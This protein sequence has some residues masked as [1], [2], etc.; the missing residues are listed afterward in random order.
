M[1][2]VHFGAGNIGR[3]FI[4]LLLHKAGHHV[5]FVDVD[6]DLIN[7]INSTSSYRVIETGDSAQTHTVTDFSGLNSS[8]D[9]EKVVSAI[10]AADI[11]TTAVGP[12]VLPFIAPLIAQALNVRTTDSPLAIMACENAL[13]ATDVLRDAVANLTDAAI[14]TRAVFANTAVDRIVPVQDQGRGLDVVVETF[15]EWIVDG[16]PFVGNPPVV[17]GAHFVD[18]LAPFIERKLFTVNTGHASIAYLG[19]LRGA[20]TIAE[21]LAL[22]EVE[23]TVRKVLDETAEVLVARH[24]FDHDALRE[25]A[26][27]TLGRFRNPDLVDGVDRVGRQPMR[28]LSRHERLIEPSASLAERGI[29]ATGLLEV[30][31]AAF[32]FDASDDAES[33]ELQFLVAQ[34]GVDDLCERVCGITPEHPLF[35]NLVSALRRTL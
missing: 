2:A 18:D 29:T 4:G 21:A 7:K 17:A 23:E 28:K 6:A 1:T 3:G 24:G 11:V 19:R 9:P 12:R 27:Q 20:S 13:G 34:L 8:V 16:T 22:P 25:Y 26:M 5:T 30:I 15:C 31:S 35:P 10:S 14:M 32:Q 33:V